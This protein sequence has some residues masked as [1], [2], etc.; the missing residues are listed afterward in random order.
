M[1]GLPIRVPRAP[2][3]RTQRFTSAHILKTRVSNSRMLP[4]KRYLTPLNPPRMG[5]QF[6]AT[7]YPGRPKQSN[8]AVLGQCLDF[9]RTPCSIRLYWMNKLV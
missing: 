4:E 7:Y 9:S 8:R 1:N 6:S 3:R 2:R 5:C